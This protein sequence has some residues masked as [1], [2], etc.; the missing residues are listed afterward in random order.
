MTLN[1]VR[2]LVAQAD[3]QG[4]TTANIDNILAGLNAASDGTSTATVT[5]T[6]ILAEQLYSFRWRNDDNDEANA[7]WAQDLNIDDLIAVGGVAR[8][9][10]LVRAAAGGGY[11]L[12]AAEDGTED[13]FALEVAT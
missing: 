6:A 3:G 4:T 9:R 1:A 11:Q 2:V 10:M 8:L 7:T 5:A 13:W 12:E